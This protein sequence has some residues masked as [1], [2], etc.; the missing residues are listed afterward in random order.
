MNRRGFLGAMIGLAVGGPAA[1]LA[2][3]PA[4][5]PACSPVPPE[6]TVTF[7]TI[8][9]QARKLAVLVKVPNELLRF[10]KPALE[11]CLDYNGISLPVQDARWVVEAVKI[12]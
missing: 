12:A 3:L 5:P 1:L 8:T 7:G 6:W 4:P 9:L 2:P 11:H 10:N